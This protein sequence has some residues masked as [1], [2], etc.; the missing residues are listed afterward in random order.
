MPDIFIGF[1]D[2]ELSAE[3]LEIF[4][5]PRVHGQQNLRKYLASFWNLQLQQA[6]APT[7]FKDYF[8]DSVPM[9]SSPK[10]VSNDIKIVSFLNFYLSVVFSKHYPLTILLL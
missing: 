6:Q 5:R 2:D 7:N 1:V 3:S 10:L 8:S 4:F 9:D